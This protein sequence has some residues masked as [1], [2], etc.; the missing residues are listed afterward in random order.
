V[1]WIWE[2]FMSAYLSD[3][4][5]I[6]LTVL[7]VGGPSGMSRV[8]ANGGNWDYKTLNI[9]DHA[10]Y[11][12]R[13]NPYDWK[14][15]ETNSMDIVVSTDTF[16]HVP[17]FWMTFFEIARVLKNGG[18]ALIHTPSATPEHPGLPPGY[19][20]GKYFDCWR[21]FSDGFSALCKYVG[22]REIEV[23]TEWGLDRTQSSYLIM[24]KP[25]LTESQLQSLVT[26]GW[27]LKQTLTPEDGTPTQTCPT[28]AINGDA[29]IS[30]IGEQENLG[31]AFGRY[32]KEAEHKNLEPYYH[33][34]LGK[35][36][37]WKGNTSVA[38]ECFKKAI[39]I[40]EEN[41]SIPTYKY[42][43]DTAFDINFHNLYA[44]LGE[45]QFKS[46]S[47][48]AAIAS[49][50]RC[51]SIKSDFFEGPYHLIMIYRSI[52]DFE[53]ALFYCKELTKFNAEHGLRLSEEVRMEQARTL[54]SD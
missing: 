38:V 35:L 10:D 47:I 19:V 2:D 16:E 28:V 50:K 9:H 52:G 37:L 39:Q 51:V 40:L 22:F 11:V 46:G 4:L 31:V 36:Q 33:F 45:A 17:Y 1:A 8:F 43:M 14:S 53:S 26:R 7:D 20:A 48:D 5:D 54:R 30:V 44:S 42:Y 18:L 25:N 12:V 13:D 49:L 32:E 6:K 24:Q 41:P 27:H 23:F 3:Y 34:K 21:F 15:V 29:H